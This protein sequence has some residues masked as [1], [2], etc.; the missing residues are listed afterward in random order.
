MKAIA[1]AVSGL[2]TVLPCERPPLQYQGESVPARVIFAP[3]E[4]VDAVCKSAAGIPPDSPRLILACTNS[5]NSTI[6][7]PD[8]CLY[9]GTYPALL[10][11]EKAHLRRADGSEGWSH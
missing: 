10:C 2:L 4:V 8:P 7:M 3:P 1:L 6:L 5:G 9:V 11:H